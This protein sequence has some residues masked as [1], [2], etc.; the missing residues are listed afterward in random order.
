[1]SI[2]TISPDEVHSKLN[3]GALLVDIRSADEH[4]REHIPNALCR[5]LEGLASG[6]DAKGS[7]IVFHCRGGMR[8]QAN[9]ALLAAA[10]SGAPCFIMADGIDGWKRAGLP[11]IID[12]GVPIDIMRQVQIVAGGLVLAGVLLGHLIAPAFFVLSAFVGAGLVFAGATGFCGMAQLLA[13]M[14]WNRVKRPR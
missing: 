1:M 14:P 11:T 7:A 12:R 6:I 13:A 5:P 10:A 4:A 9:A 8:T 2:A 3:Q